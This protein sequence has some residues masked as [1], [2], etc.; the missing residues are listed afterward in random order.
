MTARRRRLAAAGALAALT[1]LAALLWKP[2]AQAVL[3]AYRWAVETLLPEFRVVRFEL[4]HCP[5][6]LCFVLDARP[7]RAL[8]V[9]GKFLDSEVHAVL[10]MPAA[11]AVE[12]AVLVLGIA[13]LWAAWRPGDLARIA[14]A[15]LLALP[16]VELADL[17]VRLAGGAWGALLT[18]TAGPFSSQPGGAALYLLAGALQLG[19]RYPMML[20][21]VLAALR[22]AARP[23]AGAAP[24]TAS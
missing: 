22:L 1:A 9:G 2:Y 21:I 18:S 8:V 23:L 24:A 17:P 20:V 12:H 7:A 13:L 3:P 6:E 16:I 11:Q 15:A 5:A 10:R 19:L 4:A 14:V